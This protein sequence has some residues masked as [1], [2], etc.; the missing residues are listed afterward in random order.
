LPYAGKPAFF[1]DTE[2]GSDWVLPEFKKAGIDVFTA[3]TRAFTDLIAA[4]D[5]AEENASLLLIDSTTHFWREFRE[6]YARRKAEEFHRASYKL[7]FNDN[8]FIQAEW[9]KF[10]DKLVNSKLHIILAGRAGFEWDFEADED[11]PGRKQLVK[12]GVKMKAETEMAHEPNLFVVMKRATDMSAM[13][14]QHVAYVM[15]DR[16]TALDGQEFTNPTFKNFLP[17]V[18]R[19]N[20]GGAH[21]GVDTSR[22]SAA[23]IP[24]GVPRDRASIQR[25][26]L[27]DEINDL[28]LRHE[29]GGTSTVEKKRRSELMQA[30]FGTVSKTKIEEALSLFDLRVGYDSLHQALEGKPS[31]YGQPAPAPASD[32]VGDLPDFLDRRPNGNGQAATQTI[33]AE[34]ADTGWM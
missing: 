28:L 31:R 14:E 13:K 29:A 7:T 24:P 23:A 16:S 27:V 5:E 19:I 26:I 8:Q 12:T 15:K 32:D 21:L 4:V 22:T 25:Q 1:L 3:K 2:T 6:T 17:H 33:K 18:Q 30:H 10:T 11:D 20:L 34:E 9:G